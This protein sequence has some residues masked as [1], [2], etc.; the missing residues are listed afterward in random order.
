LR[1]KPPTGFSA[2]KESN[3]TSK[4]LNEQN[5][6]SILEE[7]EMRQHPEWK[8]IAY[9]SPTTKSYWTQWKSLA[10]RNGIL[11]HLLASTYR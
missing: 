10:L 9:R 1:G 5:I 7:I 6:G 3:F 4:H 8:D 2:Y 11:G